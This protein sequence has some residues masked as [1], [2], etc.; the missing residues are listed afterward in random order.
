V[1]FPYV[2]VDDDPRLGPS[3]SQLGSGLVN[4]SSKTG[5]YCLHKRRLSATACIVKFVPEEP[6]HRYIADEL[7]CQILDEHLVPGYQLPA[8]NDLA[9]TF[10]ASRGTVR[11]ALNQLRAE[12]AIAARQGSRWV[13][14]AAPL[15]QSF[16]ELL[17]FSAWARSEGNEPGG[18]DIELSRRR[19]TDVDAERLKI[20]VGEPVYRL[21]RV[22]TLSDTPVMIERTIFIDEIGRLLIDFDLDTAS[23]YEQLGEHGIVFARAR[24]TIDA[25]PATAEDSRLLRVARRTPLLRQR[26]SSTSQTGQQLEWSDDRYRGDVIAFVVDNTA[27]SGNLERLLAASEDMENGESRLG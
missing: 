1:P 12:G 10:G 15:V 19:A 20:A 16:S 17:S 18:T 8:E 26:R 21:L 22:R 5:K 23:I 24:H 14:L 11:Q 3:R 27:M 7:R 9:Q 13:V 25:I 6:L 2:D 4:V